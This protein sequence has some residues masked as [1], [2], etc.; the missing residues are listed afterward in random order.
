V[1]ESAQLVLVV[2]AQPAEVQVFGGSGWLRAAWTVAVLQDSST[3]STNS[4]NHTLHWDQSARTGTA[5]DSRTPAVG[6]PP[7][8]K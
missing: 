5:E 7:P 3:V 1:E 8:T 2:Q 4:S 6:V